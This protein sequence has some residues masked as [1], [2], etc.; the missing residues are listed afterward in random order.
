METTPITDIADLRN[1]AEA[2]EIL[3]LSVRS[4]L[5]LVERGDLRPAMKLPGRTG[6]YLFDVSDLENNKGT[7]TQ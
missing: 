1:T 7:R 6:A 2:A 5:R 4:V 3:G